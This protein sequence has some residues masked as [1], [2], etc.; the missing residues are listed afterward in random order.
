[1]KGRKFWHSIPFDNRIIEF[2]NES[3]TNFLKIFRYMKFV[4]A[5]IAM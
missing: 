1:L 2:C 4:I 3:H 5:E